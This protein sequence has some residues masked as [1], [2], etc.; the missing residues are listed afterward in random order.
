MTAGKENAAAKPAAKR[1]RRINLALQGGGAHGAF[2]WGALDRLLEDE[3]IEIA[4]VSG[5]SAGALNAVALKAGLVGGGRERA[6]ENLA[7]LWGEVEAISDLRMKRWMFGIW[8]MP[9]D[10]MRF[11]GEL[12]PYPVVE[13]MQNAFSPYEMPFLA[14][15]PLAELVGNFHLHLI[16]NHHPPYLAISAT[17]V[18][19]GK[20]RVFSGEEVT[21]AV[22]LAS[23]CLPTVFRAVELHDERTGRTEAF[24]DGG[25]TGNPALFPLY[26]KFLPQDVVIVNINPLVR[27][28]IPRTSEEIDNRVNEISFNASLLG[29]LRAINFVRE[30]IHEG[31]VPEGMMKEVFVHM[32]AD[33][34]LMTTLT[35][36]T[37]L[38]AS[39]ALLERLHAAGYRAADRFLDAHGDDLNRQGTVDLEQLF[40]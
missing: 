4:G 5:T 32:I 21:P 11:W 30:L 17:N 15:N 14:D 39:P 35:A 19:T 37:K 31:R 38:S 13:A 7:W 22:V 27:N 1:L 12:V 28:E 16:G 3:T 8:P 25:Y 20:I 40:G 10:V 23:A 29:E 36:E 18:R 26:E 24:W 33:D 9:S 34:H 6:R 2:T